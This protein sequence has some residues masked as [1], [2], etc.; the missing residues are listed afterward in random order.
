MKTMKFNRD[1]FYTSQDVPIYLKGFEY[2]VEDNMV[3]RWLKRGGEIV[4][5][6]PKKTKEVEKDVGQEEIS[7]SIETTEE[8]E[9]EAGNFEMPSDK[10]K[11]KNNR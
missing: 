3:D 5:T 10:K 1:M 7:D 2:Q 9:T 4:E 11:K 8:V 6:K